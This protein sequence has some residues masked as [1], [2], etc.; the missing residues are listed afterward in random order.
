MVGVK[1]QWGSPARAGSS[2]DAEGVWGEGRGIALKDA[3]A[4]LLCCLAVLVG[5]VLVGADLGAQ[6]ASGGGFNG[7]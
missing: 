5:A 2:L 1:G 6:G 3:V 4:V 7:G